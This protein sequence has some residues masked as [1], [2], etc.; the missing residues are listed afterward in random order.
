MHHPL[1]SLG[2]IL[3]NA[4]LEEGIKLKGLWLNKVFLHIFGLHFTQ[5]SGAKRI[6]ALGDPKTL[7]PISAAGLCIASVSYLLGL[8]QTSA[9]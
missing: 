8:C 2:V 9:N 5:I 4:K 7:H 3:I 1:M 6:V